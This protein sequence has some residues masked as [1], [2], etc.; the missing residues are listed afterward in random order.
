MNHSHEDGSAAPRLILLTGLRGSGKTR[1]LQDFV[2]AVHAASSGPAPAIAVV[3]VEEGRV[4]LENFAAEFPTLTLRKRFL[5]CPCCMPL[6]AYELVHATKTLVEETKSGWLLMEVPAL[7]IGSVLGELARSTRWPRQVVVCAGGRPAA[8]G[9]TEVPTALEGFA[10]AVV[11]GTEA[12]QR[13]IGE[14]LRAPESGS[15]QLPESG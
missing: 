1:W 5:G 3:L 14:L 6:H 2:R 15:T 8:S 9:F 10:D 12:G 4:R 13:V 7:A 11:D